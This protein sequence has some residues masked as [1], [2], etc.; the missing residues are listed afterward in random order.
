MQCARLTSVNYASFHQAGVG[1]VVH[2]TRLFS[3]FMR[4]D[5]E[6]ERAEKERKKE[7]KLERGKERKKRGVSC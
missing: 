2:R 7:R 3:T 6:R 5:D 1:F 4:R